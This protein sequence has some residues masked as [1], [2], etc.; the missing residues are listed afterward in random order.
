[1]DDSRKGRR[2]A[3]RQHLAELYADIPPKRRAAFMRK[4][5]DVLTKILDDTDP[6]PTQYDEKGRIAIMGTNKRDRAAIVR[7]TLASMETLGKISRDATENHIAVTKLFHG[8]LSPQAPTAP[9]IQIVY[10]GPPAPPDTTPTDEPET[11]DSPEPSS[12]GSSQGNP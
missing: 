1:M 11:A 6:S 9:T 7:D 3:T 12:G 5:Q 8:L 2:R 4:A 10:P